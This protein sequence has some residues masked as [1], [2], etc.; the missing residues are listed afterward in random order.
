M[1]PPEALL[2]RSCTWGT[3]HFQVSRAPKAG[4]SDVSFGGF[5]LPGVVP[6]CFLGRPFCASKQGLQAPRR[7]CSD[8]ASESLGQKIGPRRDM[9]MTGFIVTGCR[10][11]PKFPGLTR[12]YHYS[13]V[14]LLA[15]QT[16]TSLNSGKKN[17]INIDFYNPDFPRTFLTLMPGCPGV[18]KFLP[19]TGAAGKTHILVRTSM[20]FGADVHDQKG[21]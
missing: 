19:T 1:R 3:C 6:G 10:C 12:S 7:N 2:S 14:F 8:R 17:N 4:R 16:L 15:L 13:Y 5:D 21:C 11:G 9:R 18:K 20:I